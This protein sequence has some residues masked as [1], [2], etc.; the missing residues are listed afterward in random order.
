MELDG[1]SMR[2]FIIDGHHLGLRVL[3]VIQSRG[4]AISQGVSQVQNGSA[5]RTKVSGRYIE[6]R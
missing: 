6:R 4:V 5:F 1:R 2:S 3:A